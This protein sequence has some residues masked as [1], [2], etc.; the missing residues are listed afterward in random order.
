MKLSIDEINK[1]AIPYKEYFDIMKISDKQKKERIAFAERLEDDLLL[2][3]MLF[4]TLSDYSV[5]ND[6]LIV[7]ELQRAYLNAVTQSGIGIDDYISEVALNF[8]TDFVTSTRKHLKLEVGQKIPTENGIAVITAI[9]GTN[10]ILNEY[11]NGVLTDTAQ[12]SY[13]DVIRSTSDSWYISDDRVAF[14]AENEANTVMNYKDFTEA[15]KKY[16]YKTWLTENDMRVRETHVPLEGVTIP[17]NE[18]FVVGDTLMR[19]PKD[20]EYC[21]DDSEICNCRC[22]V[23][24]FN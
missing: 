17:V 19:Y 22:S 11:V 24:Y 1:R 23:K 10:V 7:Q 14:N 16:K 9:V 18:M 8:A 15:S 20:I 3:Y 5:A 21:E 2:I 4:A 13:S 6:S 12:V